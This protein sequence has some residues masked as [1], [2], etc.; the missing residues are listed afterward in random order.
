MLT[1]FCPFKNKDPREGTYTLSY[2][3]PSRRYSILLFSLLTLLSF[4][5]L[6]RDAVRVLMPCSS[7]ITNL[8]LNQLV[9]PWVTPQVGRYHTQKPKPRARR[10]DKQV[11]F[12]WKFTIGRLQTLCL[13]VSG[14]AGRC[15]VV[16]LKLCYI[17][18]W[19]ALSI[20]KVLEG[21]RCGWRRIGKE[22][23]WL[24]S[25]DEAGINDDYLH[26]ARRACVVLCCLHQ[27][28]RWKLAH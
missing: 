21:W 27:S 18:A 13:V 15:Q 2:N 3:S 12:P 14:K 1:S 10:R 25:V 4:L 9:L 17:S 6:P 8:H 16:S 11:L 26:D 23:L 19:N 28:K 24:V 22:T 7:S 5:V 20:A